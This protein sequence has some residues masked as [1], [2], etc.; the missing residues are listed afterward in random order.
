MSTIENENKTRHNPR[1]HSDPASSAGPV[2]RN[3]N[4]PEG[5]PVKVYDLNYIKTDPESLL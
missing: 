3:V 2:S 5:I 1:L 4:L